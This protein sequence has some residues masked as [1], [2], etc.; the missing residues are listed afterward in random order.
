[1]EVQ[2]FFKKYHVRRCASG[3]EPSSC[4]DCVLNGFTACGEYFLGC[5][6]PPNYVFKLKKSK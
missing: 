6:L 2:E 5:P 4:E 3:M 1:M